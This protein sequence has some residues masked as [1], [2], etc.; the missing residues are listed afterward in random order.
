MQRQADDEHRPE[1]GWSNPYPG[2]YLQT[3]TDAEG[4]IISERYETTTREGLEWLA[5]YDR[6]R[7]QAIEAG[8]LPVGV[9]GDADVRREQRI[10]AL[11]GPIR[12]LEIL[13]R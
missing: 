2:V 7:I 5:E 6:Q 1:D 12:V 9:K 4:N 10:E 3:V 11:Q 8:L 13:T